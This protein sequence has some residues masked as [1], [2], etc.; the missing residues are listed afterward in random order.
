MQ[1]ATATFI[2]CLL[3]GACSDDSEPSQ[4]P[5]ESEFVE[6][7]A[8]IPD[9]QLV[10]AER[11]PKPCGEGG[12]ATNEVVAVSEAVEVRKGPG[13][14]FDRLKNE[15]ASSITGETQY[16]KL[17]NTVTVKQLCRQS[18][19]SEVR[20]VEP[21]WLTKVK[22]WVPNTV[23]REIE[24]DDSGRRLIVEE[25]I[26]WDEETSQFRTEIVAILN[27]IVRENARCEKI[28]MG[29][30][31]KSPSRSKPGEPV[32]FVTCNDG[33]DAFNV[34]FEPEEAERE[35][36][37]SATPNV[38]RS[39]AVMACER[40]AKA[41]AMHPSSVD[42]SHVMDFAFIPHTSGRSRVLSSFTAKN[43]SWRR[44]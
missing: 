18:E 27:R 44:P 7:G 30:V 32:F 31:S 33:A 4:A 20:I 9:E 6:D 5:Q 23:L 42:F 21:S 24:R 14:S 17:D 28:D 38:H 36:A 15:K 16:R 19:W 40:S 13:P 43:D 37:F 22:G 8:A 41:A 12:I 3:M 26:Y 25:D 1:K 11:V 2:A 39:D 34:W 10:S 29:A 35:R